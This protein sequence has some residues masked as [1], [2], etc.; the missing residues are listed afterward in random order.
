M[1]LIPSFLYCLS[2]SHLRPLLY[3]YIRSEL[4]DC[5]SS[6]P[7][8]SFSRS[9]KQLVRDNHVESASVSIYQQLWLEYVGCYIGYSIFQIFRE[10]LLENRFD[11]WHVLYYQGKLGKFSRKQNGIVSC[12][13]SYLIRIS[14][15][16]AVLVVQKLLTSTTVTVPAS[17]QL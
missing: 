6:R 16:L 17:S 11:F 1:V 4:H 2:S 12:R 13:S 15:S 8:P 14:S 3:Q 5:Q 9:W 7:E 10:V